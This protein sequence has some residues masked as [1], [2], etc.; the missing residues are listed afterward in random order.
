MISTNFLAG[1]VMA[2]SSSGFMGNFEDMP[3]SRSVAVI[4]KEFFWASSN[5]F[6]NIGKVVLEEIAFWTFWVIWIVWVLTWIT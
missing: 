3:I 6:D 5:T 1:S 4:F 2:P